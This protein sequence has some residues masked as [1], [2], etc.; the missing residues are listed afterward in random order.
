MNEPPG[1]A[2][3]I[4]SPTAVDPALERGYV[5]AVRARG[6]LSASAGQELNIARSA[7]GQAAESCLGVALFALGKVT[8]GISGNER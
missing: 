8:A 3:P 1:L 2:V 4:V 7:R 5:A 6:I